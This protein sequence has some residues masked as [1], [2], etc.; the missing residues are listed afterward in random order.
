M[1]NELYLT[2]LIDVNILQQIQDAFSD[3]TGMAALTADKNGVAVTR[4]SNFSDFCVKYTRKSE[5]GNRLCNECDRKGAEKT[6]ANGG[7]CAYYCHAGLV[8]YAAPIMADGKM[9]GSFIG[10]QV[11][12]GE[13]DLEKTARI[14]EELGIDPEEYKEAAKHIKIVSKESIDKAAHF[15]YVVANVLSDIAYK[16]YCL[17]KVNLEVEKASHMKSDF[18]ANM[19]HEI[20]T[21]MNAVLGMTDLALR[22]EM[23][24]AAREYVH[25]IRS[26]GK[27]LL[28]IINDILDFSKIESGKMD[29]IEA[30]YEPLSV[31]NDL[32]NIVNS[33]IGNKKIDFILDIAPDFP[34]DLFGDNIRIHQILLNLL[35]N[36]VKFTQQ[37]EIRLTIGWER[38]SDDTI[39]LKASVEDTGIGIKKEDLHKLFNSFQQ[40]D[41]KRNRNIEG[42]GLG[43]AISQQ[44]LQLMGGSISVESEYNKGSIFS[45]VLPQKV[46]NDAPVVSESKHPISA[47]VMVANPNIRK[48]LLKDLNWIGADISETEDINAVK[49]SPPDFLIVEKTLFSGSIKEYAEN[50][51]Q[52]SCLVIANYDSTDDIGLPNVRIIRKPVYFLNLYNAMGISNITFGDSTNDSD[53]FTFVAP[54]AHILIVDDNSINLTVAKGLIKPLDM[55]VDTASSA[56]EAIEMMHHLKYDLIFMDHMMPEVDGVEAT[57]IIRRLMH[58]YDDVPIIALTANAV[59][60]V[61]EIFIKEGMNDFVAKPIEVSEIVSKLRKWLPQEKILPADR[62]ASAEKKEASPELLDIPGLNT[63]TALFLLGSEE[64]FRTVLKEYYLSIDR[65]ADVIREHKQ[66]G[67]IRDY[68]IEVHS[69]KSTS[70]Q[71]GAEKVSALAAELERAGNE[72]DTALINSRTDEL[73]EEFLRLKDIIRPCFPDCT[74]IEQENSAETGESIGE[75]LDRMCAALDEFDILGIEEV[76]DDMAKCAYPPKQRELY[77]K[78]REAAENSDLDVCHELIDSWRALAK[79]E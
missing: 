6:L 50:S 22:E 66:A 28:A 62:K 49:T 33:R 8:D 30:V 17:H 59:G 67:R 37:G 19:S 55:Q 60:G 54:D 44:L 12:P 43:L 39:L 14:A 16:S 10:G 63:K 26:S 68:T 18:L 48:Q 21:P 64:L 70:K 42:T 79:T 40:V 78:L 23:S 5:R 71:I 51:P 11:L 77:E 7:P 2:D 24:P 36:A 4:G 75:L 73:L 9:V 32:A 65:R 72:G 61:R 74:D 53:S 15:L 13:P 3:M 69:L 27:M 29:I 35:N 1:E 46:V 76:L 41:S 45:F 47:A 20:R 56:A 25:Q 52:V 38:S 31:I 57:H 34:K 58:N